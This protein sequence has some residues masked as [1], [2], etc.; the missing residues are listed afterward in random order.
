MTKTPFSSLI[1]VGLSTL[2]ILLTM[3]HGAPAHAQAPA[4]TA[5]ATHPHRKVSV[6]VS[7]IHFM[8]P[9]AEVTG[10]YRVLDKL[11]VAVVLGAGKITPDQMQG[12]PPPRAISIWEAGVQGR[13]YLV[14]D[15]R[16]GMQIGGELIYMHA[17]LSN[18]DLSA[19]ADGMSVGPFVGY[20]V[21]A[22]VGFTFDCQ[23]GYQ[24]VGFGASASDGQTASASKGAPLLNLN[25]GWSF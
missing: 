23:L 19:V 16:H 18:S 24:F 10:E 6:T 22:D 17:S 14:G 5:E 20:K 15:F 21:M 25:V 9:V 13:Y 7:P 11:G 4:A 12:F 3:T 2:A 8:L 1:A